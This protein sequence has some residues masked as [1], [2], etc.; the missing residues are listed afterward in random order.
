MTTVETPIC[1]CIKKNLGRILVG[2]Q[3][4]VGL[5]SGKDEEENLIWHICAAH[6]QIMLFDG[7]SWK[8]SDKEEDVRSRVASARGHALPGV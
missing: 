3:P 8:W 2:E 5:E 7:S 6:R 1:A 4:P